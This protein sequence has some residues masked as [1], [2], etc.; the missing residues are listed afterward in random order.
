M[1]RT[2][3]PPLRHI[4]S[5]TPETIGGVQPGF[6]GQNIFVI[7]QENWNQ[8]GLLHRAPQTSFWHPPQKNVYH[9]ERIDGATPMYWFMMA[10]YKSP[11]NLGVASNLLSLWCIPPKKSLQIPIHTVWALGQ[12]WLSL[13]RKTRPPKNQAHPK[14]TRRLLFTKSDIRW[15]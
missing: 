7:P 5:N 13:Q 1:L 15:L 10:P 14:K 4:G 8:V 6:L 9:L 12:I 3:K 11:P 2:Q